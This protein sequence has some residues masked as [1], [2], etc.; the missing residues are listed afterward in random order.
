MAKLVVLSEGLT[1]QTYELKVDKTTVGRVED[2]TFQIAQPSVSS[3][4]CEIWLRG[5]DVVVKDL[6]STNGTFVNGQ[7]VT[8][9]AVLQPGQLLRLG[10]VEMRLESGAGPSPAPAASATAAPAPAPG[11]KMR[12]S[13]MQIPKG[14]SL[15]QLERGPQGGLDASKGFT[16]KTNKTNKY[17]V[18]G[19]VVFVVVIAVI[20]LYAYSQSGHH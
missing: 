7:Q 15:E 3:H 13:S 17:F 5:N 2:N 9:E 8:T 18:I 10:Q 1:G 11:R 20:F 6:N 19:I 4:H 12:E 16:T 14:V